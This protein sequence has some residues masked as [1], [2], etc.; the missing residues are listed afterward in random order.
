MRA[1]RWVAT[2]LMALCAGAAVAEPTWFQVV[3]HGGLRVGGGFEDGETG[4]KR[5]LE[6]AASFGVGLEMRVRNEDRWWQ[7]WYSRQGT[8]VRAWVAEMGSSDRC[9]GS[10]CSSSRYQVA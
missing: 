3:P 1:T 9:R 5:D 4:D 6:E 7:L 2:V 8:E 10:C